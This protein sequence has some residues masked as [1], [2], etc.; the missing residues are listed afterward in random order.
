MPEQ[1]IGILMS[2]HTD[3]VAKKKP[4]AIRKLI[5]DAIKI[6][7]AAGVPI[8]DLSARR[9]EKT[10]MTFLALCSMTTST[11]WSQALSMRNGSHKS[12]GKQKHG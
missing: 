10:A 2:I 1:T 3:K 8:G 12:H 4:K 9:L 6:I 5:L 7:G 11:K